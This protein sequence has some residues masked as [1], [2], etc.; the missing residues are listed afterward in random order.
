MHDPR[1]EHLEAVYRILRYS[2]LERNSRKGM[3]FRSK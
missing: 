1:N 2:L 3:W